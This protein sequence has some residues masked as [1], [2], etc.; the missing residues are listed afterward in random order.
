MS[1]AFLGD[2]EVGP[3]WVFCRRAGDA[4]FEQRASGIGFTAVGQHMG[5]CAVGRK[6]RVG[7]LRGDFKRGT[8]A[9]QIAEV[10]LQAAERQPIGA[11]SS[12]MAMAVQQGQ[13][14]RNTAGAK[15]FC[16]LASDLCASQMLREA[17]P[18][19]GLSSSIRRR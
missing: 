9:G 16:R 7:A 5:Q 2:A 17:W 4:V 11:L 3:Q 8:R 18:A 1:G 6:A 12:A 10:L 14:L 15:R 19:T 13:G